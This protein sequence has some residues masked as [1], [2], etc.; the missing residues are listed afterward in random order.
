MPCQRRQKGTKT[1]GRFL[2]ASFPRT[3]GQTPATRPGV[4]YAPGSLEVS[5]HL[6]L[7]SKRR[8]RGKP[9]TSSL[10]PF[11][12]PWPRSLQD[13]KTWTDRNGRF[14]D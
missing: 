3:A 7:R 5:S 2:S 6:T 8:H 14:L 10:S 11:P 1:P 13:Y 9:Q 12:D 4:L